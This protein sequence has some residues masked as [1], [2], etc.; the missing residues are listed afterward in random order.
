MHT[1]HTDNITNVVQPNFLGTTNQPLA[2]IKLYAQASGSSTPVLIGQG[3]SSAAGAWS[4]TADRDL[5]DGAYAITLRRGVFS[6]DGDELTAPITD[7]YR[8]FLYG[9]Y[10]LV[11]A[12]HY[13][14]I[15]AAPTDGGTDTT[16]NETIDASVFARWRADAGYRPPNVLDWAA[17]RNVDAAALTT[18]VLADN[19]TVAAPG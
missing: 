19:P 10:H 11:S 16:V 5:A 12:P 2:T 14:S 15:G 13:R 7:S 9:L 6:C 8:D 3:V 17:R 18:S 4:I 1:S